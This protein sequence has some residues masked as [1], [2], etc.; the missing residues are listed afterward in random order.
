[1]RTNERISNCDACQKYRN[2]NP[3]EPLLSNEILKDVWNKVT[4][5]LFECVNKLYLTVID[6]TGK[7]F[8]LAQLPNGS[9]DM[10]QMK[11][12]SA[13]YGIAKVVFSDNGPQHSS[14]EYSKGCKSWDFIHK[15]SS[16][17]FPQSNGFV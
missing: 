16:P 17:T 2:L 12:V 1:M 14:H 11:S 6:Y 5:D 4:T 15:N 10:I 8:E 7:F 9:S 13:Q 3:H